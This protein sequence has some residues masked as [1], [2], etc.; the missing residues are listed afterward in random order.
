MMKTMKNLMLIVLLWTGIGLSAQTVQEVNKL[1]S[2]GQYGKAIQAM[3]SVVKADPSNIQ[4]LL[5]LGDIYSRN[6]AHDKAIDAWKKAAAI[7]PAD[8]YGLI[9]SGRVMLASNT[10]EARKLFD[11][12]IKNTKGRDAHLI[13]VVG[14]SFLFA[15][16]KDLDAAIEYMNKSLSV[17]R[18]DPAVFMSLAD[19]YMQKRDAGSAM[20]NYEYAV[21]K[22]ANK[23]MALFNIG[24]VYMKARNPDLAAQ[25]LAK[26]KEADPNFPETYRLLGDYYYWQKPDAAKAVENY[27]K[28][29]SLIQ[30]DKDDLAMLANAYYLNKQYDKSI[31]VIKD[32]LNRDPK[33]TYLYKVVAQSYNKMGRVAEAQEFMTKYVANIHPDSLKAEDFV[34][35]AEI[36][37]TQGA[38]SIAAINYQ[39]A[40]EKDS[41]RTELLDTLINYHNREKEYDELA[42]YYTIKTQLPAATWRDFFGLGRAHYLQRE[43]AKADTAFT[44]S[45]TVNGE[46]PDTYLW[47]A[48]SRAKVDTALTG[49]AVPQYEKF[50]EIATPKL[51]IYRKDLGEAY[52][53]IAYYYSNKGDISKAKEVLQKAIETDPANEI[54]KEFLRELNKAD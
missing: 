48:K 15:K 37:R 19:A 20:T 12:A 27:Q 51:D 49:I 25:Y 35:M 2:Y 21:E 13:H 44:L 46:I 26:A 14:E 16:N 43:Y 17:D 4:H 9:A 11:K 1:V 23:A 30:P 54:Y 50:I 34:A 8:N 41:T 7:N 36:N 28:Y 32:I 40:W 47:S 52:Q 5:L 10:A 38:D 42:K 31:N 33:A 29:V 24:D 22:S 3:E 53:Y 39:K 6:G 18:S 45:T